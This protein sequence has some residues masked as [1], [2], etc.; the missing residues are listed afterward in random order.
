M[1]HLLG[2]LMLYIANI[3]PYEVYDCMSPELQNGITLKR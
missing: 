2:M 3:F 1:A